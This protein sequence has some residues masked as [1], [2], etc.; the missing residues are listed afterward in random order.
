MD[1]G[2]QTQVPMLAQQALGSLS[3][4]LQPILQVLNGNPAAGGITE[5][6]LEPSA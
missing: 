6:F 1:S 5:V 2:D 4:P 3:L